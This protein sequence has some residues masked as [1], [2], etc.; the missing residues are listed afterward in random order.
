[1]LLVAMSCLGERE[2][3][4]PALERMVAMGAVIQNILLRA[5]AVDFGAGL[6]S[7]QAMASPRL[8]RL[9][10]LADEEPPSECG[11]YPASSPANFR[12]NRRVAVISNRSSRRL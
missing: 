2:P 1:M 6:T 12:T 10:G 8:Q 11:R 7:G 5:H 4:T 9:Y 3:N